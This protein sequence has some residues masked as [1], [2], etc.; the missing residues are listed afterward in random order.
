M[1]YYSN[2]AYK[3]GLIFFLN[4]LQ[5]LEFIWVITWLQSDIPGFAVNNPNS[6]YGST[7]FNVLFLE[8]LI[9]ITR[10]TELTSDFT[11]FLNWKDWLN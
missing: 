5:L 10:K 1:L 8:C 6:H 4:D 9:L 7:K 2:Q 3:S 11:G